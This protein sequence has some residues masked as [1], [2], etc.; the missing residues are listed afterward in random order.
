[1]PKKSQKRKIGVGHVRPVS[2]RRLTIATCVRR[3]E[4]I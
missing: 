2:N 1:M 4:Q 3:G